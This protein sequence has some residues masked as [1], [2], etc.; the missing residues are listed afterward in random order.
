MFDIELT[1]N[2][3][4]LGMEPSRGKRISPHLHCIKN[5]EAW[6]VWE[7]RVWMPPTKPKHG[8]GHLT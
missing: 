2:L 5:R 7:G 4:S 3:T 1:R 6:S 8:G